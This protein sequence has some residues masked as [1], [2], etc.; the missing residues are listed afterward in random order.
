MLSSLLPFLA[1]TIAI[2]HQTGA[3]LREAVRDGSTDPAHPAPATIATL[4]SRC[5]WA[6]PLANCGAAATPAGRVRPLYHGRKRQIRNATYKTERVR[7]REPNGWQIPRY[8]FTCRSVS[9]RQSCGLV[10]ST[11]ITR[12]RSSMVRQRFRTIVG[13]VSKKCY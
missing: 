12:L 5:I 9:G 3:F 1:A 6:N 11:C 7:Y 4:P 2:D 10:S 8:I 13:G